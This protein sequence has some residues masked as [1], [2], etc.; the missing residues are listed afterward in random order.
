[1]TF[2]ADMQSMTADLPTLNANNSQ[3]VVMVGKDAAG[4]AQVMPSGITSTPTAD[5]TITKS[6]ATVYDP[7]LRA[8]WVTGAGN[9]ALM[10]AG[11]T[12]NVVTIPVDAGEKITF[13]D[14]RKVM[15]A[16]TAT[17]ISGAR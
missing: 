8:I 4:R 17:G 10:L 15:A 9:L 14:I 3:P 12:A 16:T 5:G 2:V 11:D 7:P 6:D 13:L 1:M